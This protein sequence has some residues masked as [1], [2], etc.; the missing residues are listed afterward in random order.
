M[1]RNWSRREVLV[2]FNLYCRTPFGQIN[3]DNPEII[4][5]AN[6]LNRT[7]G[8]VAMK[9]VNLAH[10]DPAHSRRGVVGL[11]HGS[12]IDKQVWDEFNQSPT[13]TLYESDLLLETLEQSEQK[14]IPEIMRDTWPIQGMGKARIAKEREG[15]GFFRKMM[16]ATYE[17]RCCITGIHIPV[18]LNA[19]HIKPWSGHLKERLDPRDGFLLNVLHHKA[20]DEGL[21][22]ITPDYKVKVSGKLWERR[23]KPK[24]LRFF[25]DYDGAL[26]SSP[27]R[28]IPDKDFLD[29]HHNH[30]FEN[31]H[32]TN[33]RIDDK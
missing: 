6:T 31:L 29:W 11:R 15:Q 23:P 9:M 17:N 22:T 32:T 10:H 4:H 16:L 18:L 24:W 26:I 2:A 21:I 3:G 30:I 12:K 20:F 13:K 28:F 7:P 5:L 19:S 1:S 14:E 33:R 8:S 25:D 27:K